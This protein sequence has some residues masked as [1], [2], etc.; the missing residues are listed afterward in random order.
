MDRDW[1]KDLKVGD[2]VIVIPYDGRRRIARV[3]KVNK[4]TV[5][6][7]GY[8]FYFNGRERSSDWY[9]SFISPCTEEARKEVVDKMERDKLIRALTNTAWARYDTDKLRKVYEIIDSGFTRRGEDGHIYFY[10]NT[11]NLKI[12]LTKMYGEGKEPTAEAFEAE[13][14]E[15]TNIK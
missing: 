8:L 5:K 10:H 6:V 15:I 7:E 11:R 2:E 13:M 9:L 1:A 4:T 12:D 3:E 14:N